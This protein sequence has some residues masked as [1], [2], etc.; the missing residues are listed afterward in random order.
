MHL[1]PHIEIRI[2]TADFDVGAEMHALYARAQSG[3]AGS[4]GA[5]VSFTGLVRDR[6]SDQSSSGDV[7]GL[8]LEHYPGMTE[9]SIRRFTDLACARWPLTD[10]L[11][12]HRVG[13]LAPAAQI[14]YVQVASAHRSAAFAGAQ[15]LMDYL[16]T[17]AVFW[18]R[19]QRETDTRWVEATG[20]DRQRREAWQTD[21]GQTDN[22][23]THK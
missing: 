6:V 13:M 19:E 15:F 7:R 2:E 16:K 14:V 3:S 1:I 22:Q 11:I 17:D 21:D 23:Q 8:F 5:V 4:I 18:K 20:D 9:A 10:V 12:L